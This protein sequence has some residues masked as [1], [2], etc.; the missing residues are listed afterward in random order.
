MS[1]LASSGSIALCPGG[2]KLSPC[3]QEGSTWMAGLTV[4]LDDCC[5]IHLMHV[6]FGR[7]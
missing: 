5:V 3:Q 1:I 6:L 7:K 2:V 4:G